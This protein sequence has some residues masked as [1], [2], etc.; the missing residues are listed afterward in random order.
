MLP[1]SNI[2]AGLRPPTVKKVRGEIV[3]AL[4]WPVSAALTLTEAIKSWLPSLEKRPAQAVQ[5]R[6]NRAAAADMDWFKG[7]SGP[8]AGWART[9][10]AEYYATSVKG[11]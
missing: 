8:G 2:L 4:K 10:Y 9:E 6:A 5:Q 7:F 3:H 1:V 11:T